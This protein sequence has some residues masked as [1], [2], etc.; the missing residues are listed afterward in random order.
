MTELTY[1]NNNSTMLFQVESM[2]PKREGVGPMWR[3]YWG[4]AGCDSL[5]QREGGV[6]NAK[7]VCHNYWMT[8]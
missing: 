7:K 2:E 6:T 8:P 3:N 5:W 4:S 1:I